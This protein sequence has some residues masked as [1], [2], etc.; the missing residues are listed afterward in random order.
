MINIYTKYHDNY[1]RENPNNTDEEALADQLAEQEAKG[2]IERL[3][4]KNFT[5]RVF[6]KLGPKILETFQKPVEDAPPDTSPRIA[7]T[8]ESLI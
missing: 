8:R 5:R 1:I 7:K 3:K 2:I 4:T 6:E